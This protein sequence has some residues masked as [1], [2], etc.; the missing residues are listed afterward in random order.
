MT[1]SL[2]IW[3]LQLSSSLE[4]GL[5]A[6]DQGLL[7]AAVDALN[8]TATIV[9]NVPVAAAGNCE[10]IADKLAQLIPQGLHVIGSYSSSNS[11]PWQPQSVDSLPSVA[12]T[13]STASSGPAWTIN[14]QHVDVAIVQA[15]QQ[16]SD[17]S[18]HNI[19]G[20]VPLRCHL[21]VQLTIQHTCSDTPD[22]ANYSS[23]NSPPLAAA[24]QTAMQQLQQGL[25]AQQLTFI[26][27]LGSGS[28]QLAAPLLISSNSKGS[29]QTVQQA[30]SGNSIS[31]PCNSLLPL[32]STSNN[33]R[34]G[35]TTT[36]SAPM[37]EFKPV[38]QQSQQIT[39]IPLG[40][41]VLCYVPATASLSEVA[42]FLLAPA[43]QHQLDTMQQQLVQQAAARQPL[44]PIKAYHFLPPGLSFPVT[45]CYSMLHASLETTELKLQPVRQ[46]LH[47]LLGLPAIVPM[48]RFANALTWDSAGDDESSGGTAGIPKAVRLRNVHN[49]L[50]PPG[51]KRTNDLPHNG[52]RTL[53][54]TKMIF[55]VLRIHS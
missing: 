53:R 44:S 41:D 33:S 2:D 10:N 24:I 15:G 36:N 39:T 14:A 4:E 32:Q 43:L 54:V 55:F 30:L 19:P 11:T 46:E 29:S 7:I 35:S 20:F 38:Q 1:R 42:Q 51:I 9:G 18:L 34:N 13:N 28:N 22:G 3:S 27:E 5:R 52:Q 48:L 37:F 17:V 25:L 6:G 12:A 49:G 16:S 50:A 47:Q 21:D 45:I 31:S 26:T 40:L 8:R 23:A